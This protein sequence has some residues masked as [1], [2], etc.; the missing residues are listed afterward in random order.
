MRGADVTGNQNRDSRTPGWPDTSR[1]LGEGCWV[2][3]SRGG[4][5]FPWHLRVTDTVAQPHGCSLHV[6]AQQAFSLCCL[7]WVARDAIEVSHVRHRMV[8]LEVLGFLSEFQTL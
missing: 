8:G 2:C 5:V 4:S 1:A 3:S 7:K 6:W